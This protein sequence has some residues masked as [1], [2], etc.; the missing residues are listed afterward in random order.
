M[1]E[2]ITARFRRRNDF[3]GALTHEMKIAAAAIAGAT[4]TRDRG[5]EP[6]IATSCSLHLPSDPHLNIAIRKWEAVKWEAVFRQL[7]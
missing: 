5:E 4:V 7:R 1:A 2:R 6:F 3:M